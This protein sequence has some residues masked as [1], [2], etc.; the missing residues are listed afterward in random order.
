MRDKLP[1]FID[2]TGSDEDGDDGDVKI[3]TPNVPIE[4]HPPPRLASAF[5]NVTQ[6]ALLGPARG[7]T[8]RLTAENLLPSRGPPKT[9]SSTPRKRP[10]M[11]TLVAGSP[12]QP[13]RVFGSRRS[14]PPSLDGL[15]ASPPQMGPQLKS[16]APARKQAAIEDFFHKSGS[17]R[18]EKTVEDI[19]E[20]RKELASKETHI[21]K[22]G[23]GGLGLI[24]QVDRNSLPGG[25]RTTLTE[26][27][28]G[29]AARESFTV[30]N[31]VGPNINKETVVDFLRT[32]VYPHLVGMVGLFKDVMTLEEQTEV[33][34]EVAKRVCVKP[35]FREALLKG[36]AIPSEVRE[37]EIKALISASID[38]VITE[39]GRRAAVAD[40]RVERG[41]QKQGSR[42]RIDIGLD[43]AAEVKTLP[44]DPANIDMSDSGCRQ[45]D[46]IGSCSGPAP[47]RVTPSKR[48]ADGVVKASFITSRADG[49]LSPLA[50]GGSKTIAFAATLPDVT[51]GNSSVDSK[52]VI[53]PNDTPTHHRALELESETQQQTD[54]TL[55]S[56]PVEAPTCRIARTKGASTEL[57]GSEASRTS[58][59]LE[60]LSTSFQHLSS[61]VKSPS[62]QT[63]GSNW[64][65]S[66]DAPT[67]IPSR[68]KQGKPL[69]DLT[70]PTPPDPSSS[71]SV[72]PDKMNGRR[73]SR[74]KL[75]RDVGRSHGSTRHAS[76]DPLP[77]LRRNSIISRTSP[78][79]KDR[80]TALVNMSPKPFVSNRDHK[81]LEEGILYGWWSEGQVL[82]VDFS[83]D[84]MAKVLRAVEVSTTDG[85][86]P[87]ATANVSA[88]PSRNTYGDSSTTAMSGSSYTAVSSPEGMKARLLPYFGFLEAPV[89]EK[90]MAIASEMDD[91]GIVSLGTRLNREGI[92]SGRDIGDICRFLRDAAL[93][94]LTTSPSIIRVAL[95]APPVKRG[96]HVFSASTDSLIRRRELGVGHVRGNWHHPR[97]IESELKLR[98]CDTMKEWRSWTGGS[99]DA[100]SVA[101]DLT[102]E[103]FV[104]GF[105]TLTDAYNMQYNRRNSLVLGDIWRNTVK[106]LPDHRVPRPRSDLVSI[107][108]DLFLYQ[109]VSQV[110]FGAKGKRMY[111][112]SFDK[113][114]K[115]WDYAAPDANDR[116]LATLY[117]G[118]DV[119]VMALSDDEHLA[120]GSKDDQATVKIWSID[121]ANPAMSKIYTSFNSLRKG[122]A[123]Y[124]SCMQWGQHPLVSNYL[125]VGF[126]GEENGGFGRR[127]DIVLW[128]AG[129]ETR[130]TVSPG[131]QN[132]FDVA[133]HP[134][135]A[136]FVVGCTLP[137]PESTRR[138][139]RMRTCVRTYHPAGGGFKDD[140]E[141]GC[142]AYDINEVTWRYV[143]S[144]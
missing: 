53:L 111:S 126:S 85:G 4:H 22:E 83:E 1:N 37:T 81:F 45:V 114:V 77:T 62:L 28:R 79:A 5:S 64:S 87:S 84:E 90:V 86:L 7:S 41:V 14:S 3:L 104:A 103:Y 78:L 74:R 58:R 124:P 72:L 51:Q 50:S 133:W 18:D 57:G 142:P 68:A 44:N 144:L 73:S 138:F 43:E 76:P 67:A 88:L 47:E 118:A 102:G 93:G 30:G 52:A 100:A 46:H 137:G 16:P 139:N 70:H 117:Q 9:P 107:V 39:R 99:S 29:S 119:E 59:I 25:E 33:A 125:L 12:Q 122:P 94:C 60:E 134:N 69:A 10:N 135:M 123:V 42:D 21:A 101:W 36:N 38:E 96:D 48:T 89:R 63:G 19:P 61:L 54:I 65:A 110:K 40:S 34:R 131:A 113:T 17:K 120:T 128:D 109:T 121:G 91:A 129:S 27:T 56:P 112:A 66:D 2:L 13:V 106:E 23:D 31:R 136:T 6:D 105:S 71:E 97:A 24:E 80:L 49:P 116:L 75:G 140:C 108:D 132:T 127:G 8:R 92:L 20:V 15:T 141:L 143:D 26:Q 130:V 32:Q 82:H 98:I 11:S 35:Y 95:V 115:I 55:Q